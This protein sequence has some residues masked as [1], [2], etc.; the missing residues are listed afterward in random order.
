[1]KM[2]ERPLTGGNFH[3]YTPI[4][5]IKSYVLFLHAAN[6]RGEGHIAKYA[7]ITPLQQFPHLQYLFPNICSSIALP[8]HCVRCQQDVNICCQ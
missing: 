3:D 6:F 2:L 1:M 5:F 8:R 4:S 7:K